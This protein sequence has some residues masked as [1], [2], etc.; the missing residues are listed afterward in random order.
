MTVLRGSRPAGLAGCTVLTAGLAV[1]AV[2]GAGPARAQPAIHPLPTRSAAVSWGYGVFG[3]LGN[4]LPDPNGD[5]A[6]DRLLPGAMAGL[7]SG[8]VAVSAGEFSAM[9]LTSDGRAWTWG[10]NLFGGL[11]TGT[12]G[13]PGTYTALAAP[14]AGLA[15]VVQV[16]A[17]TWSS[18]ALRA[19]GTVWS[20]GLN[21]GS[22]TPAQVPGLT[23]VTQIAV[24]E[25][26]ALALRADGTV[27][28]WGTAP[29]ASSA[30]A[31]RAAGSARRSG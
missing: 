28:G 19:D 15:D 31:P 14:V 1:S 2:T 17:G 11:G 23:G 9:A 30:P 6:Q 12:A 3:R 20:W 18:Y 25:N 21:T 7:T 22:L 13:P 27:W 26:F 29:M 5:P 24:S 16:A 8:V 10:D 4:G